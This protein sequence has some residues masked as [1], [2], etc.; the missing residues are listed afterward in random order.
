MHQ[1][2]GNYMELTR[3]DDF[4]V[5]AFP[6]SVR[7]D[8]ASLETNTPTLG[9]VLRYTSAIEPTTLTAFHPAWEIQPSPA[10][11][12]SWRGG[13]SAAEGARCLLGGRVSTPPAAWGARWFRLTVG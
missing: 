3:V 12:F 7:G 5:D 2:T 9:Y 11:P 8:R 6:V 13:V 10:P 1:E 4:H